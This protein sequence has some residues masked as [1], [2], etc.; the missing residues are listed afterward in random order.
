MYL[1]NWIK[2]IADLLIV[3][4][5]I[6]NAIRLYLWVSLTKPLNNLLK[7]YRSASIILEFDFIKE[8]INKIKFTI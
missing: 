2:N 8:I 3:N 7:E 6:Q 5:Q 1:Q 4:R